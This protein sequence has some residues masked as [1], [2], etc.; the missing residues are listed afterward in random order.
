MPFK[1]L[2]TWAIEHQDDFPDGRGRTLRTLLER[3]YTA[4]KIE[5]CPRIYDGDY[6]ILDDWV[7]R[8]AVHL[9]DDTL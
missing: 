6:K 7:H 2:L 5:T 1:V 3:C 8:D 9:D 4:K